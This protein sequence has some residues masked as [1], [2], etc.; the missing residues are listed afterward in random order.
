MTLPIPLLALADYGQLRLIAWNRCERG[1]IAEDEAFAL[2]EANWRFVDPEAMDERERTLLE[3][4][5]RQYGKG[6]LNV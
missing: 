1:A 3:R 6:L 2:Y 4:L 5:K